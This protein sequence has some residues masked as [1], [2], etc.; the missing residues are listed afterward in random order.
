ML[1]V[2]GHWTNPVFF[3]AAI[4][5]LNALN[6]LRGVAAGSLA[7]RLCTPAIAATQFAVFMALLNLGRSLASASLGWI[8][9]LGGIPAM[10]IAMIVCSLT[11]AVFALAAKVGR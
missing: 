9:S 11:A 5:M 3:I 6:V 8:D 7:M 2:Q 4:F 1:I 10:F